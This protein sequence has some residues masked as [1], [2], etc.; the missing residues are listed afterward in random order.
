MVQTKREQGTSALEKS[1]GNVSKI[2]PTQH[3]GTLKPQV[4]TEPAIRE[5]R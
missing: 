3:S 4:V 5:K 1:S 2:S